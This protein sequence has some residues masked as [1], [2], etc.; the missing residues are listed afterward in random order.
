MSS[1]HLNNWH[2]NFKSSLYFLNAQRPKQIFHLLTRAHPIFG[3]FP[4]KLFQS[5]CS[6]LFSRFIQYELWRQFHWKLKVTG[7]LFHT[8]TIARLCASVMSGDENRGRYNISR[9]FTDLIISSMNPL[10]QLNMVKDP[11]SRHSASLDPCTTTPGP[12]A[13]NLSRRKLEITDVRA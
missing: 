5:W 1:V 8:S 7:F 10:H 9:A 11:Q 4:Y 6:L 2:N 13:V 3:C 12:G